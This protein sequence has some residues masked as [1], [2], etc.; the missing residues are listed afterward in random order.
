MD[1]KQ[2]NAKFKKQSN[3][4]VG[5]IALSTDQTIERDFNNICKNLPLDVF[6]NRI[7]N[8]NP[9]TK[10][11]LLKME[12]DL[13]SVTNK[14]LPKI[15]S[16]IQIINIVIPKNIK[17]LKGFSPLVKFSKFKLEINCF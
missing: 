16:P 13:A 15:M 3:P 17:I 12:N 2:Y 4:K 9:L 7:H 6:I 10:E 14:I 5:L 11:N 8:Q 1:I